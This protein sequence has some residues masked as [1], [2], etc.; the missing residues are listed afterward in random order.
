MDHRVEQQRREGFLAAALHNRLLLL[1]GRQPSPLRNWSAHVR[2][3]TRHDL[4]EIIQRPFPGGFELTDW[5]G[6]NFYPFPGILA[7]PL[8][9]VFPGLAWSVFV[10]LRKCAPY[11]GQFLHWPIDQQLE[12]NFFLGPKPSTSE[13]QA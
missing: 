2:G 7:R 3:Y 6:S 4:V 13:V 10:R 1:C 5:A 8:A 9:T 12:T 11:S